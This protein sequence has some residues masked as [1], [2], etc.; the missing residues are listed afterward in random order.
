MNDFD[1]RQPKESISARPDMRAI[2]DANPSLEPGDTVSNSPFINDELKRVERPIGHDQP[3]AL[4]YGFQLWRG[5]T[6]TLVAG[7]AVSPI[8]F[9]VPVGAASAVTI[10]ANPAI[11]DGVE[12]QIII[13]EGTSDSNTVTYTSGTGLQLS[14]DITLG[15]YDQI[16]LQYNGVD[17]LEI[18]RSSPIGIRETVTSN[19]AGSGSPKQLTAGDS[20]TI[21]TNEGASVQNY[22][23]LPT[24]Q[25]GLLFTF[26]VQDSDGIRVNANTGDTIR[27][28]TAVSGTAGYT[29]ST[30]VG[31]TVRLLA[32]NSVEWFGIAINGTWTTV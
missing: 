8:A 1:S 2:S 4:T 16:M 14:G 9:I 17:W 18:C 10:T 21:W 27:M 25:A 6:Q 28:V 24:A 13:L 5:V 31:S 23:T 29:E 3:G 12:G 22:Y 7:T 26:I 15:L 30:V 11:S 20:G 32:I 19:V